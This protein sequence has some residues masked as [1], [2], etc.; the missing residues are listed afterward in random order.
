MR[1]V[2]E[3]SHLGGSE[4]LEVRYPGV[5][6]DIFEVIASVKAERTKQ[7]KEK[8]KQG[9]M[10][11]DPKSM[12]AQFEKSFRARGFEKA[13]DNYTI[14]VP[15]SDIRIK[16]AYKEID[17]VRDG[18]FVEVQLGKYPYMFYD[19]A[20]F[21]YFY[22]EDKAEVGVEIVPAH[23]LKKEMSS[24][25]SYGEQLVYDIKR[26]RRHFPAVPIKVI[27][28]DVDQDGDEQGVAEHDDEDVDES[29]DVDVD[30]A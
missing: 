27:L 7:S 6:K 26:L 17:F 25:V 19:M 23:T 10:L 11:F 8:T 1:V 22:N 3:Y 29:Q 12:N 2:Y 20:K 13:R 9:M 4:I 24:G 15:D 5:N 21:Q 30:G 14:C 28:I 16:N 18:V